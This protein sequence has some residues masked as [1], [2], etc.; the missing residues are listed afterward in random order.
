[1]NNVEW[2]IRDMEYITNHKGLDKVAVN[3]HWYVDCKQE[4]GYGFA[5]GNQQLN[6]DNISKDNFTNFDDVTLEQ[7]FTWMFTAMGDHQKGE[8]EHYVIKQAMKGEFSSRNLGL[9]SNW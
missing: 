3:I 8:L 7:V 4:E 5:W 1:M 9:P 2:K 6:V